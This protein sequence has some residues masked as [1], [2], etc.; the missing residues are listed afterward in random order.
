M[1][2]YTTETRC[3]C[4]IVTYVRD[5]LATGSKRAHKLVLHSSRPVFP[6]TTSALL[7]VHYCIPYAHLVPTP[8]VS[9]RSHSKRSSKPAMQ[10]QASRVV[11]SSAAARGS[12]AAV[13]AQHR[14]PRVAARIAHM[15]A[16]AAAAAAASPPPVAP[17][18][19]W[20]PTV[21]G[22]LLP[23]V[24]GPRSA[25]VQRQ[26]KETKV[27]VRIDI[28]GSGKCVTQTPVGFLNHML[29]QIASHGLFDVYVAAEGDTWIDDHHTVE[30]IA[31]AFGGALSQALGDRKVRVM[32]VC[33]RGVCV[34]VWARTML[35]RCMQLLRCITR[36]SLAA[37]LQPVHAGALR[38]AAAQSAWSP[39]H[40][41]AAGPIISLRS[42]RKRG[43]A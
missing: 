37:R 18:A 38:S 43:L 39:L 14:R 6:F 25:V 9:D 16:P 5:R 1:Y 15:E 30:D 21:S 29:D 4:N 36:A 7:Q 31:L 17:E 13:G 2:R 20:T 12:S 22:H 24:T 10:A 32:S 40:L 35:V 33:A 26:T 8:D 19:G 27:E 34:V 23:P 3:N 11:R 41:L 42:P 28:D